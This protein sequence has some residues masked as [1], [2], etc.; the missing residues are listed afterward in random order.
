MPL[1][2]KHTFMY[3]LYTKP[4][5]TQVEVFNAIPPLDQVPYN[6]DQLYP[7][8]FQLLQWT[9]NTRGFTVCSKPS[10]VSGSQRGLD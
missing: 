1:Y 4:T 3:A 8:A 9:V 6:F 2:T 7:E 10:A 5:F